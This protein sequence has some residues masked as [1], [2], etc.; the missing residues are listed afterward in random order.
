MESNNIVIRMY[1]LYT[2]DKCAEN[3]SRRTHCF[4]SARVGVAAS[5]GGFFGLTSEDAN[6][7]GSKIRPRR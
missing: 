5:K 4:A 6:F 3:N 2:G 7:Y 1:L